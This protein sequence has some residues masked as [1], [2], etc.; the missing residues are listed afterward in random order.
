VEE[1]EMGGA[2][3]VNGGRR[4]TCSLLVGKPEEKR[5]LGRPRNRWADNIKMDLVEIGW[6][7][8][9]WIDLPQ[10]RYSSCEHGNEPSSSIK[11]WVIIEW[12]YN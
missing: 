4:G 11:C 9:D 12:L 8:M 10:D 5:S 7:G 2:C 1:V 3:G 6:S